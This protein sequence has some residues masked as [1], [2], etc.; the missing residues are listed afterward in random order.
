MRDR[1][2]RLELL[3]LAGKELRQ[4]LPDND[5]QHRL[6]LYRRMSDTWKTLSRAVR[7]DGMPLARAKSAFWRAKNAA[8]AEAKHLAAAGKGAELPIGA[9]LARCAS[10]ANGMRVELNLPK[11]ASETR[12]VKPAPPVMPRVA[13][14]QPHGADNRLGFFVG[15]Y[16]LQGAN[17]WPKPDTSTRAAVV[18]DGGEVDLVMPS[19][20]RFL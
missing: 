12:P 9:A 11:F 16:Q 20:L 10:Q 14:D 6:R 5:D 18:Y 7:E 15:W 17:R 4:Y 8:I 19:T 2:L 3:V 13:V 1:R